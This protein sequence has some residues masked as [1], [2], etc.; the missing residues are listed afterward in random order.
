VDYVDT[1]EL[2]PE[3]KLLQRYVPTKGNGHVLEMEKASPVA[4]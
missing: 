4:K 3:G 1:W 2:T